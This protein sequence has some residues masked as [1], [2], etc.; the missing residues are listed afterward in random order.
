MSQ[1]LSNP[2]ENPTVE[3]RTVTLAV[4]TYQRTQRLARAV[5][6]MAAGATDGDGWR[7]VEILVVDNNPDGSARPTVD[8]L[9]ETT[10]QLVRYAHEPTPGIVAARNRALTE[11]KGDVLVFIDDDEVALDG[12]P[13]GLLDVMTKTGAALVGGP[14]ISEFEEEPPQWA[15]ESGFFDEEIVPTGSPRTWLSTC[16]LAVDLTQANAAGIRFDNRYPHGEDV[17]F[18]RLA[19][20]RGLDLRWSAT[21]KVKEFIP[22]ERTT[23]QWRRHRQRISTEAWVRVELDLDP[24]IRS[25]AV[26]TAKALVRLAQAVVTVAAG[27][28]GGNRGRIYA[29]ILLISHV[30]GSAQA[31]LRHR[32]PQTLP[33]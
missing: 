11:A 4:L 15:V 22:S 12:W 28:V 27:A 33:T 18:S 16:N 30:Q 13:G 1:H 2:A 17:A 6:T 7:I 26:L 9:A 32:R 31:L 14:V 25:R 29:G 20:H 23:L 8:D 3:V 5:T 21:A 10:G 24:S 19:A